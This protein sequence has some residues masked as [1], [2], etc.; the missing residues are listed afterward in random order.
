MSLLL[1]LTL[2]CGDK[3]TDGTTTDS[4]PEG[5]ADTDADADT[6]TDTD[7]DTDVPV[8]DAA[9]NIDLRDGTLTGSVAIQKAFSFSS[10]NAV[11]VYAS[12]NPDAT[13]DTLTAVFDKE[14]SDP[15]PTSL[16]TPGHCNLTLSKVGGMELESYDLQTD[17]G[18]TVNATCAY[19]DGSWE[20]ESGGDAGYYW[21]GEYYDAGAWKGTLNMLWHDEGAE[22]MV[23]DVSLKEWEGTFPY[24]DERT[25]EHKAS[26]SVKGLIYTEWCEGLENLGIF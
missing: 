4:T 8:S 20:Y 25:G 2:A 14:I 10:E 3:D 21:S 12:S 6:D 26:G 9:G 13:C 16:F 7:A 11:F 19:G 18:A 22:S 24:S 1:A 23:L 15:D 17:S 5:D